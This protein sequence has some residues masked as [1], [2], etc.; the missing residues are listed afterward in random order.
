MYATSPRCLA[1]TRCSSSSSSSGRSSSS[2]SSAFKALSKAARTANTATLRPRPRP[3]PRPRSSN[4]SIPIS[5]RFYS[6]EADAKTDADPVQPPR[7]PNNAPRSVAVLGGGLTGLTTAWYLTRFLPQTK[8]TIYEASN[9]LAGWID[10]ETVPV[11]TADGEEGTVNFQR[12]ARVLQS[13]HGSKLMPRYDDLVFYELVSKL[14]LADRLQYTKMGELPDR[15]IYYPDHLVQLPRAPGQGLINKIGWALGTAK[16]IIQEPLY[17]GLLP[18]LVNLTF[19]GHDLEGN[20]IL[21]GR[22]DV[23]VGNYFALRLGRRDLVDNAMSAMMH[24]IYGGDVWKLS[25]ASS[26][27][28][29]RLTP[30]FGRQLPIT[31]TAIRLEDRDLM[32]SIL[33]DNKDVFDLATDC[34]KANMLWFPDGLSSLTDRLIQELNKNPNVTI[35]TGE[36]VTAV[37]YHEKTDS[38]AITTP[39]QQRPISY[40]K[41]VSA[42]FAKTLASLCDHHLP[43]LEKSTAT[44]IQVVNLW[45]PSPGLNHPNSGFGYLLPQ[46]LSFEKNPECVLG[47][48]FDSDREFLPNPEEPGT[49]FNRGSDTVHGTKLTVMMGGHYWDDIPEEYLPDAETAAEQAKRA[50]AR[51]LGWP[52]SWAEHAVAGTK[53]CRECIPQHLVG[54]LKRMV[55]AGSELD[56]AFKGKLAVVGGSYQPPGVMTSLRGAR[57]IAA[58][59]SGIEIP[60][61]DPNAVGQTQ[62]ASVG[63]NGLE[64]VGKL[65]YAFLQKRLL[66][67]RFGSGA[68]VTENGMLMPKGGIDGLRLMEMERDEKR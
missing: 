37:R 2:S 63:D 31:D 58:Q 36:R 26:P 12:G 47:V 29:H 52:P 48:L 17:E 11:K 7:K 22:S 43:S 8:I 9:R 35:K 4:Y 20:A 40:H 21:S 60:A 53:L 1:R 33:K 38:V 27:F 56:W 68:Y 25:M 65:R 39:S 14:G 45:Y 30:D 16:Q 57:D 23:S 64:R 34:L 66:P 3:Q 41:V 50:V 61:A 59:I 24:G 18:S 19:G 32:I 54:H 6:T 49:F 42:L 51:H 44:T 28:A 13:L 46:S 67:L 5:T 62:A 10:S 15:Y 55:S